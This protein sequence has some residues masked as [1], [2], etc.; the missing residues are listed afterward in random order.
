MLDYQGNYLPITSYLKYFL[1]TK[2]ST[3]TSVTYDINGKAIY[4]YA[5]H[6]IFRFQSKNHNFTFDETSLYR[7]NFVV[8]SMIYDYSNS[9][10]FL[11]DDNYRI[12]V[13]SLKDNYIKL[14]YRNV[15]AFQYHASSL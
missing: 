3:N 9:L 12:F 14:L 6:E 2:S 11:C 10:L 13:I 5:N 7:L 15:V 4:L 8:V 1:P